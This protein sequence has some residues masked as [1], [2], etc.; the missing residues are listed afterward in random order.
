LDK[1]TCIEPTAIFNENYVFPKRDI[2]SSRKKF[3]W[4]GSTSFV[5]RGLDLIIE[6]FVKIPLCTLYIYGYYKKDEK[7]LIRLI[8]NSTNIHLMGALNVQSEEFLEVVANCS[9]VISASCSEGMSTS[10]LTCMKHSL[11]PVVTIETGIDNI[12]SLGYIVDNVLIESIVKLIT[13]INLV[14][15]EE[16]ESKHKAVENYVRNRFTASDYELSFKLFMEQVIPLENN[17]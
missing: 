17:G 12:E 11:I 16:I 1:I 10:V 15:T 2:E 7:Q 9:F 13:M 8:G 14:N 5:H 4:F 6:A 3:I